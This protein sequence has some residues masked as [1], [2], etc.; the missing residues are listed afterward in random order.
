[1][2][3]TDIGPA[4]DVSIV[5]DPDQDLFRSNAEID[6][7]GVVA[8][9]DAL[10]CRLTVLSQSATA[11]TLPSL[12]DNTIG[13]ISVQ[14]SNMS[15]FTFTCSIISGLEAFR[16]GSTTVTTSRT[17]EVIPSIEEI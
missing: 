1:M 7:S 15:T 4:P 3:K 14:L 17:V 16:D 2:C 9:D 5:I 13:P 10:L 8:T 6:V 12:P 11:N